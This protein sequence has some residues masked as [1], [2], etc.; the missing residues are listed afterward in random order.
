MYTVSVWLH[1]GLVLRLWCSLCFAWVRGC[2]VLGGSSSLRSDGLRAAWLAL[3]IV[4]HRGTVVTR[5]DDAAQVRSN[6]V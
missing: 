3:A 4:Q 1:G 2:L 6:D 5:A